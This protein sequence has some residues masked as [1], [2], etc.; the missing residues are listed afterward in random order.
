MSLLHEDEAV[1]VKKQ[2]A[3]ARSANSSKHKQSR[4]HSSPLP[5][6]EQLLLCLD[7]TPNPILV[8]TPNPEPDHQGKLTEQEAKDHERCREVL[9][10][11]EFG[12][13]EFLAALYEVKAK[14][15]FRENHSTFARYAFANWSFRPVPLDELAAA[16]TDLAM[17][18]VP[19]GKV[20]GA[21]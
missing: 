8:V 19:R 12:F 13:R 9:K 7:G 14:G 16:P 10:K 1:I 11:N 17:I 6:A 5:K 21:Q 20:G 18:R 2:N 4:E 15:L 3:P